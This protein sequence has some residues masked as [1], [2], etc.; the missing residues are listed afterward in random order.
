[1]NVYKLLK[2]CSELENEIGGVVYR[3]QFWHGQF[4]GIYSELSLG[5]FGKIE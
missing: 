2:L 3:D 4:L 1:M 5:N